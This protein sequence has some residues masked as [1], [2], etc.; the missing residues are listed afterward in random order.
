LKNGAGLDVRPSRIAQKTCA[1]TQMN[2]DQTTPNP[3]DDYI[4]GFPDDVRAMLES[5]RQTIRREAPEARETIKYQMPTF[6]LNGNL[7]HFAA[8]KKHIGLYPAPREAAEFQAELS[9]YGGEKDAVRFP[10][11]QPIPLELIGRIVRFRVEQRRQEALPP[12]KPR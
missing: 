5:I 10:L 11:D 7:I 6:V 4:A 1:E 9:A 3:M 8:F 12:R 2:P